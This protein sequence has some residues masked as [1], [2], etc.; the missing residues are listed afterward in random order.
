MLKGEVSGGSDERQATGSD[1]SS[2]PSRQEA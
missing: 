2:A 1:A